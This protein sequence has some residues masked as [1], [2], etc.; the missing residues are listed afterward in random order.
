MA[1]ILVSKYGELPVVATYIDGKME[2]LSV[3]HD[4]D[5]GNVYLCRVDNI[6]KNIGSA[7][8]RYNG[9]N[10]G[11]VPLKNI[12]PQSVINRS[13][14]SGME[15]RQGDEIILQV[16][17]EP[18]KLKKAKLT[19]FISV[20]GKYSVVTLGKRGLGISMKLSDDVRRSLLDAFESVYRD[21]ASE[22]SKSLFGADFGLI[23]RTEVQELLGTDTSEQNLIDEVRKDTENNL[24]TLIEILKEGRTRTVGS[25]L[26]S[27]G[28]DLVETHLT[29]ARN[30]LLTRGIE[31]INILDSSVVYSVK[32]DIDKLRQNK[33][34]LKSGAFLIIEQ[35]ESFNAID[36]NTG[37]AIAGKKD[38]I[39]KVNEEAALEIMRQ[40]RLRNLTGMILIDFINMKDKND[41]DELCSFVQKLCRKEDIHTRFIDITGLGIV[42][43]TRNKNDKSLKEILENQN[44][45][46]DN[47]LYE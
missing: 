20:S 26:F 39:K 7:F 45:S 4:S 24:K 33:V 13:I 30:F 31:E 41:V 19:S 38:I 43:L 23:I 29:A 27:K 10:I 44:N 2:R 14:E 21:I 9:D 32:N 36:V 5:R 22:Q 3:I 40:L 15:I 8:V 46:V 18:Q 17:T 37:K 16:E 11:Y 35:L 6:V 12:L 34:W 1:D 25:C 47:P 28:N 42:E